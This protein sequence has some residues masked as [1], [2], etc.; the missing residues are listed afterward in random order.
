MS[1]YSW[2]VSAKQEPLVA[3]VPATEPSGTLLKLVVGG[4][5]V[6]DGIYSSFGD[7][8][9]TSICS[10]NLTELKPAGIRSINVLLPYCEMPRVPT[11]M[12]SLQPGQQRTMELSASTRIA[13]ASRRYICSE[14]NNRRVKT[15]LL[16]SDSNPILPSDSRPDTRRPVCLGLWYPE[17]HVTGMATGQKQSTSHEP[18]QREI[19]QPA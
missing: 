1:R 18:H 4:G 19:L 10:T 5:G 17:S 11:E 14:N 15:T 12:S 3:A 2:Y 9:M 16:V 6:T 7:V 13:N 8:W